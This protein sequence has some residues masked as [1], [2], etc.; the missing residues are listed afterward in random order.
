MSTTTFSFTIL[1]LAVSAVA[2][3][4][5]AQWGGSTHLHLAWWQGLLQDRHIKWVKAGAQEAERL[6]QIS[7]ATAGV[8]AMIKAAFNWLGHMSARSA[9]TRYDHCCT[10]L[11][12]VAFAGVLVH[13]AQILGINCGLSAMATTLIA[14]AVWMI[15]G[16]ACFA[17]GSL[18]RLQ[19]HKVVGILL[20]VVPML[21]AIGQAES[22]AL[23]KSDTQYF[24]WLATLWGCSLA[25]IG[26][27]RVLL[28]D[29]P[30]V[31]E[32]DETSHQG[33]SAST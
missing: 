16:V 29:R 7:P 25:T 27:I 18:F 11:A 1:L 32:Q 14:D 12:Q 10:L 2:V 5:L 13:E 8:A 30:A 33:L 19:I 15:S 6:I 23:S 4:V 17:I 3:V 9:L 26:L 31:T 24:A 21:T 28:A 22:F 20:L